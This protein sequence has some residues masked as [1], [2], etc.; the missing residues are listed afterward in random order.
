MEKSPNGWDDVDFNFLGETQLDEVKP[1]NEAWL[2]RDNNVTAEILLG[3]CKK[4]RNWLPDYAFGPEWV[5]TVDVT[6]EPS[7]KSKGPNLE[8]RT[9][10][11]GDIHPL[12]FIGEVASSGDMMD[13]ESPAGFD[14]HSSVGED[15]CEGE[16]LHAGDNEST[17]LILRFLLPPFLRCKP[18]EGLCEG[19]HAC[20][21]SAYI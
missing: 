17:S 10:R 4:P 19:L 16:G 15:L 3:L 7:E 1:C 13:I 9:K 6:Q 2:Y 20:L 12:P 8:V 21:N 5:K 14:T 11:K 18:C